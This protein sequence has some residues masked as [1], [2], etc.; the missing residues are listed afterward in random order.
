MG[1]LQALNRLLRGNTAA[2]A[3]KLAEVDCM[4]PLVHLLKKAA[5]FCDASWLQIQI[6]TAGAISSIVHNDAELC[7]QAIQA[8][9][10]LPTATLALHGNHPLNLPSAS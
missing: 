4:P 10:K 8:G 6:H 2:L 7:C 3:A 9:I 1:M 5:S